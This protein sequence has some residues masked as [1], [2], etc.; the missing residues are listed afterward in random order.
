M[1]FASYQLPLEFK[2]RVVVEPG[3]SHYSKANRPSFCA[4]D[5]K[6][7]GSPVPSLWRP[8]GQ[9]GALGLG[10]SRGTNLDIFL[11]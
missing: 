9:A 3:G 5:L 6:V 4:D 2:A 10:T 8:G 7:S 1:P 11:A